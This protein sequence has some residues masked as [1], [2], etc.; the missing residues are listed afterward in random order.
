MHSFECFVCYQLLLCRTEKEDFS[1]EMRKTVDKNIEFLKYLSNIRR[2]GM[3]RKGMT[4]NQ[5]NSKK[6]YY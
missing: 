4:E 5:M 2:K 6:V 1:P 3:K